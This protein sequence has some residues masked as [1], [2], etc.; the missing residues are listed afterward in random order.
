MHFVDQ[1]SDDAWA[2]A[3]RPNTKLIYAETPANP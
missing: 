3:L 1:T 2:E